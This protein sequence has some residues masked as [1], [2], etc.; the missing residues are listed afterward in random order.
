MR[1]RIVALAAAVALVGASGCCLC[2]KKQPVAPAPTP[3]Y[4]PSCPTACPSACPT[5]YAPMGGA[6]PSYGAGY[7]PTQ[8]NYGYSS[9]PSTLQYGYPVGQTN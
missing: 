3:I 8:V 9:G 5:D 1:T 7:A 6:A 4:T 2:K